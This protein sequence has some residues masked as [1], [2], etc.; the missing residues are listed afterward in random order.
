[1]KIH[2]RFTIPLPPDEAWQ[3]LN[4]IPRVAN[5]V[6]GA[7][8]LEQRDDSSYLGTVAVR[9]GPVALSFKGTFT[10]KEVDASARRVRAEAS[11]NEEKARGNA[12]A[13]VAF[14]LAEENGG[15]LVEV[16]TDLQ[17]AGSIA[18]YARGGGL[19]QST[20]QVLMDQFAKNLAR[21]FANRPATA[22]VIAAADEG[23]AQQTT[24]DAPAG[25]SAEQER[26]SSSTQADET[27]SSPAE[28]SGFTLLWQGLWHALWSGLAR[29]FGRGR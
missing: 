5:C 21:E 2:N 22:T 6:P 19:I 3:V 9:L 28:I 11:G 12:R 24:A 29:L 25:G 10:Y 23:P 26:A 1:M 13:D 7:K 8:L 14:S 16:D 20:A 15:T 4:D 18:Q 17:L 27:R